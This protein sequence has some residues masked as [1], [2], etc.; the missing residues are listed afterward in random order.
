MSISSK[1]QNRETTGTGR[2]AIHEPHTPEAEVSQHF[3]T[4]KL[5]DPVFQM[6]R[7]GANALH[8]IWR[9]A[10][11]CTPDQN[12]VHKRGQITTSKTVYATLAE[13]AGPFAAADRP[14]K[15]CLADV[16]R[17]AAWEAEQDG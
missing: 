2:Y 7:S 10:L 11:L 6:G 15:R 5:A 9:N 1:D 17:A 12:L 16:A 14:C 4:K 13:I 3:E 8:I